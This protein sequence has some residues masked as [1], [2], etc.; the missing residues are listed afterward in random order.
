MSHLLFALLPSTEYCTLA[1][2]RFLVRMCCSACNVIIVHY[3]IMLYGAVN[4]II[5]SFFFNSVDESM[6][7]SANFLL[8][9]L[10]IR[11]SLIK[12]PRGMFS[13]DELKCMIDYVCTS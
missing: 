8:E 13:S 6:R 12:L 3:V 11:D 5:N 7:G 1:A 2:L 4:N 10:M 9:L